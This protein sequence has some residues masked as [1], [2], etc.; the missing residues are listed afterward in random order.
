[1]KKKSWIGVQALNKNDAI[2]TIAKNSAFIHPKFRHTT[3]KVKE[4]VKPTKEYYGYY[5]V[6]VTN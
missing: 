3:G 6:E 4:K 2:H 1:M 5:E